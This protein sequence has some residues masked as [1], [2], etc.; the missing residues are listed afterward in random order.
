MKEPPAAT[1][2][3]VFSVMGVIVAVA[4]VITFTAGAAVLLARRASVD[5][6]VSRPA[7]STTVAAR[8][9]ELR[10]LPAADSAIVT[11]LTPGTPVRVLGRSP[12]ARWLVVGLERATSI[13][14]WVPIDAVAGAV[15]PQRLAIVADA[16]SV[17]PSGPAPA[18]TFTPDF[19]DLRI[20]RVLSRQNRLI[21]VVVN[22][23]P[24]DLTTPIFIAL[25]GAA[26]QRVETK[27]GE[28]LRAR[29]EVE[30]PIAGALVQVRGRVSVK[31]ATQPADREEDTSNNTWSGVVEPDV[32]NDIEIVGAVPAGA[33]GHLVVMVRN[34]SPIPIAGAITLT[35][36]ESPP[37]TRLIGRIEQN[38]SLEP[39]ATIDVQMS[40]VQRVDLTRVIVRLSSDAL[41]DTVLANDS[42]PR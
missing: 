42:Y 14:G 36:R 9:I 2:R 16:R 1:D 21:V 5:A 20:D 4:I 15:D 35:V 31:V 26:P 17:A 13:V 22:D 41:T 23:G 8:E 6:G 34:N 39:R 33:D 40:D 25:N 18:S 32:P 10:S 38:V 7:A 12:D 24:G 28:P 29:D 3:R 11:R 37:G 27:S 30:A 19:P